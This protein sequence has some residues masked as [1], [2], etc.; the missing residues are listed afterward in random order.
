MPAVRII[1]EQRGQN[2]TIIL[3]ISS[4]GTVH[5][6]S[7]FG[8]TTKLSF[9]DFIN[10]LGRKLSQLENVFFIMDNASCHGVVSSNLKHAL[11]N[12]PPYSPSLN[13]VEET[14]SAWKHKVKLS[15]ELQQKRI[16]DFRTAAA[17][18]LNKCQ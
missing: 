17:S 11:I 10:E 9:H 16:M 14:F 6:K 2:L 3:A 8:G 7:F 5:S 1:N 15:L 18:G 13:P 4:F 12:L